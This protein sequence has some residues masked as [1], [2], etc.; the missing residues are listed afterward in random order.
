[1][2]L[3]VFILFIGLAGCSTLPGKI[4]QAPTGQRKP[5][6]SSVSLEISAL[7]EKGSLPT[8]EDATVKWVCYFDSYN[9]NNLQSGSSYGFTFLENKFTV[10]AFGISGRGDHELVARSGALVTSDFHKGSTAY[11][12]IRA[13]D[14]PSGRRL[15]MEESSD[16]DQWQT[17]IK[18]NIT[19]FSPNL[20][21]ICAAPEV[22]KFKLFQ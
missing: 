8:R 18:S 4:A 3:L 10:P 12:S 21:M 15:I 16:F 17:N 11:L 19:G 9:D 5:A 14:V 2:K 22:S 6:N 7:F 1:M 20:Y 13:I